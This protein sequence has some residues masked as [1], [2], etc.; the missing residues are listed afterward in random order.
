[1]AKRIRPQIPGEDLLDEKEI[2]ALKAQAREEVAK[3]R[4][5]Q[6]RKALLA[7]MKRDVLS[8]DDPTEEMLDYEITLPSFAAY[9]MIDGT[10]FY[11]GQSYTFA[12]RQLASV[13]DIVQSAWKHEEAAFGARDPNAFI[14]QRNQ[15]VSARNAPSRNIENHFMRV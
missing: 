10:R 14:R 13:R 5:L 7:E 12:H 1:M 2:A 8:E 6:A 4:K 9:I 11:H 15:V 3:E